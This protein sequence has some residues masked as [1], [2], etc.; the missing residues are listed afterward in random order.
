MKKVMSM[1]LCL[2][3]FV[4]AVS[5]EE[6]SLYIHKVENLPEDFIMGMD[7]SSVLALV[8]AINNS[9]LV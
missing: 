1:L 3:L 7:V 2:M 6:C 9:K 4:A 5:A 8:S